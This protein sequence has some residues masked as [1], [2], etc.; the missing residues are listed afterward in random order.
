MKIEV[1][2]YSDHKADE[3]PTRFRMGERWIAVEE[4]VD[5]WYDPDAAYFKVRGNDGAFYILRHDEREDAWT[6]ASYR[7]A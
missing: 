4:V 6:L 7:R 3:R 1:E 2:S 5:R